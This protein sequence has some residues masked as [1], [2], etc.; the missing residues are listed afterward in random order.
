[1]R[2]AIFDQEMENPKFKNIFNEV[3]ANLNIG[4]QIAELRHKAKMSQLELA[5]KVKTSRTA[6][7]R[8]ESGDYDSFNV[9]TLTRIAQAFHKNLKISFSA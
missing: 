5:Q 6:I 8:Y 2:K 9:R 3:S 4:E 7:A 1:M